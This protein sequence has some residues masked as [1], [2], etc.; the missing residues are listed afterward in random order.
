MFIPKVTIYESYCFTI[1]NIN[2]IYCLI[3]LTYVKF[4]N[5]QPEFYKL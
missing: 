5:K 2:K 4:Q 3:D 1:L